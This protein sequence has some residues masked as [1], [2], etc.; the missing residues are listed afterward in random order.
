VRPLGELTEGMPEALPKK[1][2]EPRED[3]KEVDPAVLEEL[4]PFI[5]PCD[6]RKAW[7]CILSAIKNTVFTDK[8]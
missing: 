6:S 4:L 7:C 2:A 5:D 8:E 3:R 1:A